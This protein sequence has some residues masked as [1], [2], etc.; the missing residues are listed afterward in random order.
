M[1]T[2]TR[3]PLLAT[4]L[5]RR[6]GV[7]QEKS[8]KRG[9]AVCGFTLV[10][11]LVV[12][13]IIGMLIALLLP[14]VQAA[15]EAARRMQCTNHMKQYLLALHNH[16]DTHN[17]FP[18]IRNFFHNGSDGGGDKL[19]ATPLLM[20]Y[21]ESQS[22]YDDLMSRL[23]TAEAAADR[24]AAL[25]VLATGHAAFSGKRFPTLICP[26]DPNSRSSDAYARCNI[27]HSVG[28][29][30]QRNE[31]HQD[32]QN[33]AT[34]YLPARRRAAFT[35]QI[36][37]DTPST[38]ATVRRR[39]D[40]KNI[41]AFSDGL[42][43]SIMIS[44]TVTSSNND[45]TVASGIAGST[46][47]NIVAGGN[48]SECLRL[49]DTANPRMLR[50]DSTN[51]PCSPRVHPTTSE[52]FRGTRVYM[53]QL[54]YAGFSTILPPNSPHC[55]PNSES[56]GFMLMSTSSMHTGG[57]NVGLGDGGVR[58]VSNAVDHGTLGTNES[59]HMDRITENGGIS[60]FGVWGA[61]GSINGGESRS[62]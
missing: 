17:Y 15:R 31:W 29:V 19:G 11:L 60:P 47:A 58:F 48:P 22:A 49:R 39:D 45:N 57:V 37:R 25:N 35:Q 56:A 3:L 59:A 40:E 28:D 27:V 54:V 50:C 33:N 32:N 61:Y 2:K 12:I 34:Q 21:M 24:N 6:T 62:L 14:A 42:S 46:G 44:E 4:A 43:N 7:S 30:I 13:A 1:K 52:G 38:P 16:H 26:S 53:G 8:L 36:V 41:S 5:V 23:R 55:T 9:S 10:E 51:N 20:P 18:G